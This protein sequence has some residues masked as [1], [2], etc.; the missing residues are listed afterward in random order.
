MMKDLLD[1]EPSQCT[2]RRILIVEDNPDGRETMALLLELQGH[3]IELAADGEEGIQKGLAWRPEIALIDIGLPHR[4]GYQVA[5]HLRAALGPTVILIACTAYC[6]AEDLERAVAAGFDAHLA[7]P[8][9]F[10]RL[11]RLLQS[12]E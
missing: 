5:R 4:D 9:D 10:E 11:Y 7:K 3:R 8:V 2:S 1:C 12:D 6:R